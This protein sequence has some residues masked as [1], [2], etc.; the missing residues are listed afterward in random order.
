MAIG[1]RGRWRGNARGRGRGMLFVLALLA[2]AGALVAARGGRLTP[3]GPGARVAGDD[4]AQKF[5]NVV[6]D[7]VA[8]SARATQPVDKFAETARD[9]IKAAKALKQLES[10]NTQLRLQILELNA[11]V[12][13]LAR[14]EA[15]LGLPPELLATGL[16]ARLIGE[17]AGPF[18]AARIA[19]AGAEVGVKNGYAAINEYGLV[20]WVA[21]VGKRSSRVLLLT[22]PNSRIP[23]MGETSRVRAIMVGDRSEQ[24]E[25]LYMSD[26]TRLRPGERIMTSGDGG[27]FPRGILVGYAVREK[28]SPLAIGGPKNSAAAASPVRWRVRPAAD[29]EAADFVRL[30]PNVEIAPLEADA[31]TA[32]QDA[33]ARNRVLSRPLGAPV[34]QTGAPGTPVAARPAA[35]A[36]TPAPAPKPKPKPAA[37]V[38][39]PPPS[40]EPVDPGTRDGGVE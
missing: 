28:L 29:L 31:Q 2:I 27:L 6:D 3:G 12:E 20:G 24:P 40:N 13:R 7:A 23:V 1:A 9:S 17:A 22:D 34:Q 15:L 35:A 39:V 5:S 37:P 19:N 8:L 32:L 16:T 4:V 11:R 18:S 14:Y 10:E 36:A 30:L 33:A 25:M 26:A 38:I 21:A